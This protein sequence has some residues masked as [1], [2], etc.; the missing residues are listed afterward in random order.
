[1]ASTAL[2]KCSYAFSNKSRAVT[3][4]T[5]NALQCIQ[6]NMLQTFNLDKKTEANIC[7][8]P[9]DEFDIFC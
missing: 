6:L 2:V 8:D 7:G 9:E 5:E 3:K 1:M 4:K